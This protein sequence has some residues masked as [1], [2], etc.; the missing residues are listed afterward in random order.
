VRVLGVVIA[1][2]G[3]ELVTLLIVFAVMIGTLFAVVPF[4]GNCLQDGPVPIVCP[5]HSAIP[6]TIGFFAVIFLML[7]IPAVAVF[8]AVRATRWLVRSLAGDRR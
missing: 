8:Y 4:S 6:T 2:L 7:G 1:L 3:K 5:G